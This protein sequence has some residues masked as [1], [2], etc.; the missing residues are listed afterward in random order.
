MSRLF[1][2]VRDFFRRTFGGKYIELRNSGGT[3][4]NDD[5]ILLVSAKGNVHACVNAYVDDAGTWQ[6]IDT[7]RAAALHYIDSVGEFRM[8]YVAAGANP[9]TW[10][11]TFRCGGVSGAVGSLTLDLAPLPPDE[12]AQLDIAV[13][14]AAVGDFVMH[15]MDWVN[16]PDGLIVWGHVSAPGIASVRLQNVSPVTIDA[17]PMT[18]WVRVLKR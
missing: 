10:V 4:V 14:G 3:G 5:G 8:L 7:T 17:P 18:I 6:R 9:I 15:S 1:P 13:E 16:P 11:E 2:E 12:W